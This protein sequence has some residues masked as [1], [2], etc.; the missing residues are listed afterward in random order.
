M[1]ENFCDQQIGSCIL[2]IFQM[3]WKFMS[4][5][6]EYQNQWGK[7]QTN[8]SCFENLFALNSHKSLLTEQEQMLK[9]PHNALSSI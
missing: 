2:E 7:S 5:I 8:D 6:L 9:N 4:A 3:N 1:D